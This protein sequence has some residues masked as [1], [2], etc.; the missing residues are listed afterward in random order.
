MEAIIHD[1][2]PPGSPEGLDT[3]LHELSGHPM[4]AMMRER[5]RFA[6]LY[7]H[8]ARLQ[9]VHAIYGQYIGRGVSHVR[10]PAAILVGD[11]FP[12]PGASRV[13]PRIMAR[14]AAPTLRP[15]H[16]LLEEANRVADLPLVP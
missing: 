13:R 9:Q 10:P 11:H 12:M 1:V 15:E 7:A 4:G 6:N 8:N 14:R 16:E 3:T 2:T 5:P